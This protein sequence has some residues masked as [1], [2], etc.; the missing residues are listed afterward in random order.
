[1]SYKVAAITEDCD[2]LHIIESEVSTEVIVPVIDGDAPI[3]RIA[4]LLESSPSVDAETL[5]E[6]NSAI[7]DVHPSTASELCDLGI[8][9]FLHSAMETNDSAIVSL[10]LRSLHQLYHLCASAVR[11][12]VF[13]DRSKIVSFV[14]R[15]DS[16][17]PALALV[18]VSLD[19]HPDFATILASEHR[20]IQKLLVLSIT[21]F[22]P[23]VTYAILQTLSELLVRVPLS[24]FSPNRSKKVSTGLRRLTARYL[25]CEIDRKYLIPEILI[26]TLRILDAI[27]MKWDIQSVDQVLGQNAK[28]LETLLGFTRSMR[29]YDQFGNVYSEALRVWNRLF[30]R[31]G[32]TLDPTRLAW[33]LVDILVQHLKENG[34]PRLRI[35]FLLS[36]ILAFPIQGSHF[37]E[38]DMIVERMFEAFNQL[39]VKEKENFMILVFHLIVSHPTIVIEK[40]PSLSAFIDVSFEFVASAQVYHLPLHFIHALNAL[41]RADPAQRALV[42]TQE[43]AE[44]LA[45]L[46]VHPMEGVSIAAQELLKDLDHEL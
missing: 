29:A 32:V 24:I 22:E 28:I 25:G 19:V 3:A 14:Q 23:T 34:A 33:E 17:Y 1:M 46:A 16:I 31:Y 15:P 37:L 30:L 5:C 44:T 35:L 27:F 40:F 26:P 6:M 13:D 20:L 36:N 39:K 12:F 41:I 11:E 38:R 8:F 45:E 2:L 10:A 43:A 18:L 42:E 4:A 21:T 9:T 7:L